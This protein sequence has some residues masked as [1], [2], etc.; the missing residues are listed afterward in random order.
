MKLPTRLGIPPLLDSTFE[1]RFKSSTASVADHLAGVIFSALARE[2]TKTETLPTAS[3]PREL[4]DR[5]P[6]LLFAPVQR[7]V[8]EAGVLYFGDHVIGVS[9]LAPYAGW[10]DFRSR[11]ARAV[12]AVES[13]GLVTSLARYSMKS[14][15]VIPPR[16]ARE[17]D[18][19]RLD[20]RLGDRVLDDQGFALRSEHNDTDMIRIIE[21]SP[22][23]AART[24]DN[25]QHR[26]LRV[27]IDC[28]R[29]CSEGADSWK[30][31]KNGLDSLH[32]E[33][34]RIFFGMIT[35]ATLEA[36]KPEYE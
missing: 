4:R 6:D 26:G 28:I 23:V 35:P 19:L 5:D 24:P 3:L 1:V 27:A 12:D 25:K 16:T 30:T 10:K 11:I 14:I 20:V 8:G 13:S 7:L 9:K 15:N 34:K 22:R 31:V 33:S 17:L 2:Y 36:L 32:D 18:M 29:N 21:I